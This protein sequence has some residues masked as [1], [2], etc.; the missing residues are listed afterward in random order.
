[1]RHGTESH[2]TFFNLMLQV[3]G[4]AWAGVECSG[5]PGS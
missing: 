2:W 1:M 4:L 5:W 3:A